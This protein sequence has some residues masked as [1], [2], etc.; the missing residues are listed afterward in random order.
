VIGDYEKGKVTR[1]ELV[2]QMAGGAELDEL[3][4]ELE[5]Q[6]GVE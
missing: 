4:H 1:D 2:Q 6:T 3:T 5:R